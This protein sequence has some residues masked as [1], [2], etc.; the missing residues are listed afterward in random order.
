LSISLRSRLV[1]RAGIDRIL[2]GWP[3]PVVKANFL[4]VKLN[5]KATLNTGAD[6]GVKTTE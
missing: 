3:A 1:P 6:A 5:S 2:G 4:V